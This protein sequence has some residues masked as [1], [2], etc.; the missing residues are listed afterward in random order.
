M[1]KLSLLI[2]LLAALC[3]AALNANEPP[4]Y[5]AG[6]AIV[7]MTGVPAAEYRADSSSAMRTM[8]STAESVADELG[9]AA[10][11]I[12]APVEANVT[13]SS[14]TGKMSLSAAK[15]ALPSEKQ[16]LTVAH[17]K[18]LKGESTE[19]L[20]SRLNK[21]PNVISAVPNRIRIIAATPKT[22][23][24]TS[25]DVLWGIKRINAPEVWGEKGT[26][27]KDIIAVVM[28]TG[29]LY[30][31]EDLAGNMYTISAD[32]INAMSKNYKSI[33]AG[34][35]G[36]HGAWF[37]SVVS[38]DEATG[39][40]TTEP[41][42]I[43]PVGP[44]STDAA[45][46]SDI[47]S[48]DREKMRKVGDISGHGTHVA[49]TIGAVGDNKIGV[50]GV[51]WSV[52]LMSV[53]NFSKLYFPEIADY[54]ACELD[55]DTMRGIDFIVAA[56]KAGADIRAV[57]MSFSGSYY[58]WTDPIDQT[59]DAIALKHKEL[60]DNGIIACI[61]AGNDGENFDNP[62]YYKGKLNYPSCY[63]FDNSITIGSTSDFV[64]GENRSEF[65]N[66]SSSAK[67]VD[68]FAP[69]EMILSTIMKKPI[70]SSK[71]HYSEDGYKYL[72]GTSMAAPHVTGAVALL[73]SI[74][75]DL[76]A[77]DIKS[78][79]LY[80]AN[81]DV[82]REGYSSHGRL[83]LKGAINAFK[84]TDV[85]FEILDI[86][87]SDKVHPIQAEILS[88][89][90]I[91][92]VI[93]HDSL[94]RIDEDWVLKPSVAANLC[95]G[96]RNLTTLP[97]FTASG[98]FGA[99]AAAVSILISGDKL[100]NG[101]TSELRV[102]KLK[103]NGEKTALAFKKAKGNADYKDGYYAIFDVNTAK[104][105]DGKT[106]D[107]NKDY[108]LTLFI[109]D[110]GLYDMDKRENIIADSTVLYAADTPTPSGSGG[111]NAGFAAMALIAVIPVA[112]RRKRR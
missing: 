58:G 77:G 64:S 5:A 91:V 69:G 52:G 3:A 47:D 62:N 107:K 71:D 10:V 66:Y 81:P 1:K 11:H 98:D 105:I 92:A 28:D 93:P 24:D 7:M 26:G 50:V 43:V 88:S 42:D 17:L 79:L 55:S 68:I 23:N 112:L 103:T 57:N 56:K 85:R 102:M 84:P 101:N 54:T 104:P 29:I 51:N 83:D 61:A 82:T 13:K 49:G 96:A 86:L 65:S 72:N 14:L 109:K 8:S 53:S 4:R 110:N 60:S 16:M 40:Y 76:S 59:K 106:F 22:P 39:K 46:S 94:C 73:C 19:E 67:W 41:I 78:M 35:E 108:V 18:T 89:P 2:L 9:A 25:F 63:R 111:C 27:S 15:S 75:P 36:S 6:E 38:Y 87:S 48:K 99:K 95:Q 45:V 80:G 100:G 30:D 34:F 31:H 70:I 20:I 74:Y 21:L 44:G 37:H 90:D 32:L 33:D 12:Y 97:I